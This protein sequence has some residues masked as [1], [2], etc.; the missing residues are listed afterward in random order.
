AEVT[1]AELDVSG[2]D[3]WIQDSVEIYVDAGNVK[4]GSYRYDDTQIRISADNAVSF[5]TGDEPFQWARVESATTRTDGGYLVEVAVSLLEYGGEG[6]F[7]GLDV[8]VNDASEGARTGI[9]NWADPSGAGYQS[10]ARWGVAQL[11]SA[12]TGTEPQISLSPGSVA[13]GGDVDVRLTGFEAN[14]EVDL[15]LRNPAAAGFTLF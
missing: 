4:N 11:V 14:T 15:M 13:A 12:V 7:H 1:D 6:S 10:T 3:P 8:Q 2:A 5:G 9:R